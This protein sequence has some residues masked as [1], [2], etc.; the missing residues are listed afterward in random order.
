M[1]DWIAFFIFDRRFPGQ[2]WARAR[3]ARWFAP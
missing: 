2:E 3:I 1:R